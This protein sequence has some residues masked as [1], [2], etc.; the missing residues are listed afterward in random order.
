[1]ALHTRWKLLAV[2]A[3]GVVLVGGLLLWLNRPSLGPFTGFPDGTEAMGDDEGDTEVGESTGDSLDDVELGDVNAM[4]ATPDGRLGVW[5]SGWGLVADADGVVRF[6]TDTD[7][8]VRLV[9]GPDDGAYLVSVCDLERVDADGRRTRLVP[10]EELCPVDEWAEIYGESGAA[11]TFEKIGPIVDLD[12]S[13]DGALYLADAAGNRILRYADERLETIAG[14]GGWTRDIEDGGKAL[15]ADFKPERIAV[16]PDGRVFL[17]AGRTEQD[18]TMILYRINPDGTIEAV[19]GGGS[20]VP[21]DGARATEVELLMPT[22]IAA[23]ESGNVYV[24]LNCCPDESDGFRGAVKIAPNGTL[25]V[26]FESGLDAPE[27]YQEQDPFIDGMA[28]NDEHLFAFLAASAKESEY[29]GKVVR[30]PMG[31]G[32]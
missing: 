14:S 23:D 11:R 20:A 9:P 22:D 16:G 6:G 30:I 5:G 17:L 29:H 1:M 12:V 15:D 27:D 26:M 21:T 7:E 19:G 2:I 25:D 24:G 3:A 4:V 8:H 28:A 18:A 13:S 31:N 32:D 10:R